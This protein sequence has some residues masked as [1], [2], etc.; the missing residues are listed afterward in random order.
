M[1][2]P[3]AC[4]ALENKLALMPAMPTAHEN[5]AFTPTQGVAYQ[6]INHLINSPVDHAVTSDVTEFRG[7]MQVALAYPLGVG[8]GAAQTKAQA[9]VDHFKPPQSITSGIYI[10]TIDKTPRISGAMIDGDRYV[11]PVSIEWRLFLA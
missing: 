10:I 8:R 3:V 4:A 11:I 1:S 7:I 2:I 6:R 5:V 9:I